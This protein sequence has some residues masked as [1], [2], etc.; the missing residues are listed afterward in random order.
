MKAVAVE[1][2]AVT[3]PLYNHESH[4]LFCQARLSMLT[5]THIRQSPSP[6][7]SNP[8]WHVMIAFDP[9]LI[10][11]EL[12]PRREGRPERTWVCVLGSSSQMPSF[13]GQSNVVIPLLAGRATIRI[14]RRILLSLARV[15][16]RMQES[17][18][19]CLSYLCIL[20]PDIGRWRPIRTARAFLRMPRSSKIYRW[21]NRGNEKSGQ[22]GVRGSGHQNYAGRKTNEKCQSRYCPK[23]SANPPFSDPPKQRSRIYRAP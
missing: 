13:P 6:G 10:N 23:E 14:R 12:S 4:L 5:P 1:E 16:A 7:M 9:S 20:M 3:L 2:V 11:D 18:I 19:F 22:S 21:K 8:K 15:R 17:P